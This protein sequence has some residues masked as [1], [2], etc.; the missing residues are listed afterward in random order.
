MA[1]IQKNPQDAHE[2]MVRRR[3]AELDKGNFAVLDEMFDPAYRL[4]FPTATTPLS[5][6]A[7][8]RF[9]RA[10]YAAFPDLTHT[11]TE[12]ISARDKV[13]TRWTARGTHRGTWMGVAGTGK[14]ISLAGINIY[15]L[16]N[17][18]LAESHVQWDLL[19]LLR[20]LGAVTVA[21]IDLGEATY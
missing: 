1:D 15:T 8:K 16:K 18:K 7:T 2:Q 5:L 14:T 21:P 3:F 10:L 13:V 9:Y 11:I 4:N 6:D 19:G 17:G 20:Q 12:Q